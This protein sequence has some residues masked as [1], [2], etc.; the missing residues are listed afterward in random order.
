MLMGS[1]AFRL[2]SRKNSKAAPSGKADVA[3][4]YVKGDARS[5]EHEIDEVAAVCGEVF[6]GH[7]IHRGAHLTT[8]CF[9]DG[10][11]IRDGDG[12]GLSSHRER[13]VQIQSGANAQRYV[14]LCQ[15]GETGMFDFDGVGTYRQ[16][17]EGEEAVGIAS[18]LKV[19]TG[20]TVGSHQLGTGKSGTGL[21][22]DDAFDGAL[23][24][25]GPH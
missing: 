23:I 17:G 8:G 21:I 6:N 7:I 11:F 2:R 9:D 18:G 12:L 19:D 4:A 22:D 5:E 13:E 10:G 3:A 15:L 14:L 16:D 25:L 20:R 24:P 1:L